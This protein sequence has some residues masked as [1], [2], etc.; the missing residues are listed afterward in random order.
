L[1]NDLL[2]TLQIIE[3]AYNGRKGIEASIAFLFLSSV[4]VGAVGLQE[5]ARFG[6][7]ETGGRRQE[8]DSEE[9]GNGGKEAGGW[10][11]AGN[12]GQAIIAGCVHVC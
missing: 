12:P 7:E 10:T 11:A 8:T 6:G 5:L 9:A 1:I 4:T 3:V 2:V